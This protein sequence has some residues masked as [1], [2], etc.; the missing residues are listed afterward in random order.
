MQQDHPIS[1][2]YQPE[3]DFDYMT[4][5]TGPLNCPFGIDAKNAFTTSDPTMANVP[6]NFPEPTIFEW[7][8]TPI[9]KVVFDQ[10]PSPVSPPSD[11]KP[12]LGDYLEMLMEKYRD[13]QDYDN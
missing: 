2:P 13:Q 7:H 6:K 12:Y 10:L 11:E 3:D 1:E 8:Q 4:L 5:I 9:K